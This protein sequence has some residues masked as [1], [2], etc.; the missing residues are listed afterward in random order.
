MAEENVKGPLEFVNPSSSSES[1]NND[2]TTNLMADDVDEQK[3]AWRRASVKVRRRARRYQLARLKYFYAIA[4]FD[5]KETANAV[6]EACDGLEY[7]NSG[8]KLDL[9]FVGEA[10][11]FEARNFLSL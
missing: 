9:R 4:E 7:E 11:T 6:F 1:E 10:E 5:S 3:T 8:I 2:E